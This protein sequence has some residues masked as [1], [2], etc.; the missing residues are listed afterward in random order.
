MPKEE[1]HQALG[2]RVFLAQFLGTKIKDGTYTALLWVVVKK[3]Y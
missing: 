2:V 3:V 1:D